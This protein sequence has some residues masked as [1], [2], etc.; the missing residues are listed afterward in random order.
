MT[1]FS[2]KTLFYIILVLILISNIF[3]INSVVVAKSNQGISSDYSL[4][5]RFKN[6]P[7]IHKF[8]YSNKSELENAL[9]KFQKSP[10]VDQVEKNV[11]YKTTFIPNDPDY[12]KQWYLSKIKVSQAWDLIKG[13]EEVVVAVIDSGVQIDHPD[14]KNNI[15]VNKGEIPGNGIDDDNNGYVDDT[16]GW[17]FV[18]NIPDPNPKIG[19]IYNVGGVNHGTVVAGIVA[20]QSD[21]AKGIAGVGYKIKIMPLRALD[22]QGVGDSYAVVR[23]IDY[24][25][26]KRVDVINMS[27]VGFEKSTFLEEAIQRAWQAGI[28]VVAAAGNDTAKKGDDLDKT[29]MYPVCLDNQNEN[30]VIGVAALDT[31]NRKA[32]FS[33]FGKSC[34]DISAPGT[35]FYST[36]YFNPNYSDFQDYYGGYW[37]GTSLATPLVSGTAALIKS[38]NSQ[39][40]NKQIREIILNNTT[41]TDQWNPKYQKGRLGKGMLN[42]YQ[43]VR[44]AYLR[45]VTHP[46][47]RY[48]VTGAGPGGGPHIRIFKTNGY[49]V[50]GFFAYNENFRG[51]VNIAT[52]D[53]NGDGREEIITGAGFGGGPHIKIFTSSG[54]LISSFFAFDK[55]NRKGVEVAVGD[56]N[57]DKKDE[58][59]TSEISQTEPLVKIFDY[60]GNL[61]SQFYAYG[62]DFRGGVTLAVGDI[63]GDKKEEIITGTY[64]GGGPQVRV[65]DYSGKVKTQF[66]A[67][68]ESFHGG[69]NV[70]TG[71]LDK[72]GKEEIIVGV[73]SGV[74]PYVRI[75]DNQTNLRAQ[76]L[77]F[78][79]DFYGGV[80]IS[81]GDLDGDSK[82]E[83]IVGAGKG[84]GPQIRIL[85]E[86]ERVKSQFFTYFK[87]FRGGVDVA[88]LKK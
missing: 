33:N 27:F 34:V 75:F 32:D 8:D 85:D 56:V 31:G 29:P 42:T 5:V 70:A 82:E 19:L 61:I 88:T 74:S 36:Q 14:L 17:D 10:Q 67:F 51:G 25:I 39:F 21:N 20:A 59:I 37:S 45:V 7:E 49:P 38:I 26:Q 53:I 71:D 4:L 41:N 77:A 40:S 69:I 23:A 22:S 18:N 11:S 54:K 78:Q 65:F 13:S 68:L 87:D 50:G 28:V 48:V 64:S 30:T 81:C 60:Q 76:F 9:I 43:A 3:V 66:F 52:G 58:I 55:N 2:K 15:W 62:K 86:K 35:K 84:G 6:D 44:E 47:A 63:D 80:N 57:G 79:K 1:N 46:E 73:R 16:N 24:A 83:I 12:R 72:D